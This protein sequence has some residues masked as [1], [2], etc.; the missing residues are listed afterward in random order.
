MLIT[1]IICIYGDNTMDEDYILDSWNYYLTIEQELANTS[2]YVEPVGQEE[3]Y[4]FEFARIIIISCVE[5]EALFKSICKAIDPESKAGNLGQYKGMILKSYPQIVEAKIYPRRLRREVF[6]FEDWSNR[7]LLWWDAY[8]DIKHNRKDHIKKANYINA[9]TSVAAV[10]ILNFY[11]AEILKLDFAD[12]E[13]QYFTSDYALTLSLFAPPMK[14][15][16][17]LKKDLIGFN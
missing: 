12:C 2:R 14:L 6:P 16:Q 7:D 4:S 9:V 10:Y 15:F 1:V 17:V 5:A 13:S 8:S 11:L 3:V